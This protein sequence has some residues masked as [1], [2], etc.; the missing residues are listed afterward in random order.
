MDEKLQDE[1]TKRLRELNEKQI[2]VYLTTIISAQF[3]N[4]ENKTLKL[5]IDQ[6]NAIKW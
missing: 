2:L 6:I 5:C 1:L 3:V 4:N